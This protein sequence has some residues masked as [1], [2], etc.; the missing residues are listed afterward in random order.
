M[1]N[2]MRVQCRSA[3]IPHRRQTAPCRKFVPA[4]CVNFLEEITSPV[5]RAGVC[6]QHTCPLPAPIPPLYTALHRSTPLQMH[7][8]TSAATG[9]VET[10]LHPTLEQRALSSKNRAGAATLTAPPPPRMHAASWGGGERDA[11]R[12]QRVPPPA[13]VPRGAAPRTHARSERDRGFCALR[14]M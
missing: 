7:A 1:H 2:G 12:T 9:G 4:G 13:P 11:S 8:H 14:R 10:P 3:N 6:V 5:Q